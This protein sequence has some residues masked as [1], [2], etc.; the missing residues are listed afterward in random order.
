MIKRLPPVPSLREILKLYDLQASKQL[1]QN[2]LLDQRLT[3]KWVNKLGDLS[4]K[5]IMEVGPGPGCLT[6]SILT[7][8]KECI[9]VEKDSRFL[10]AL[11]ILKEAS[12]NRLKIIQGD[13]LKVDQCQLLEETSATPTSWEEGKKNSIN[14]N[15]R[16]QRRHCW[17]FTFW[18]CHST[19]FQL[20]ER[21]FKQKRSLQQIWKNRTFTHVPK[22]SWRRKTFKLKKR[23]FLRKKIPKTLGE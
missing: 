6:R 13:I 23:E 22:G 7:Y 10:P 2:F 21:H 16:E 5:T 11:Q 9:V 18:H 19:I 20:V 12:N 1:S 14:K 17:K 15:K 8:G 4:K 3:D